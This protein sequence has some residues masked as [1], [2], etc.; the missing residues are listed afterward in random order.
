[1]NAPFD[2]DLAARCQRAL[3]NAASDRHAGRS[4][5]AVFG[6]DEA[7]L[8]RKAAAAASK[9]VALGAKRM[10]REP[11]RIVRA[12]YPFA[13]TIWPMRGKPATDVLS[14][15]VRMIAAQEAQG[16]A[17][18]WTFDANRLVALRQAESALIEIITGDD[19]PDEPEAA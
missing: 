13:P 5:A 1:M 3:D 2:H 16:R 14:D 17:G 18:T 15:C 11:W 19:A 9:I 8:R 6:L 10:A 4:A 7:A 12:V